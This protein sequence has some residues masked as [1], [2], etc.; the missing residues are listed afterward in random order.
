MT[1]T[2]KPPSEIHKILREKM[3]AWA[4]ATK[5]ETEQKVQNAADPS[6]IMEEVEHAT[7]VLKDICASL[8]TSMEMQMTYFQENKV[9]ATLLLEVANMV[10]GIIVSSVD[11]ITIIAY[12][13]TAYDNAKDVVEN[14]EKY[15]DSAYKVEVNIN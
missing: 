11:P 5:M 8:K 10:D 4:Q 12:D 13:Q 1:L 14:L 3:S 15:I 7:E 6:A 2:S 9:I